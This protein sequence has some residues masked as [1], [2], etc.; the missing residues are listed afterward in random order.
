M[1][2]PR[3]GGSFYR[4]IDDAVSKAEENMKTILM[5]LALMFAQKQTSPAP[6]P[7][8]LKFAVRLDRTA[9]WVGDQFHYLIIVDSPAN[10]EFVLDNL[11][12]ETVNMDP[13]QVL[14]VHANPAFRDNGARRLF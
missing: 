13:F 2:V 11:T 3:R 10:Y 12:K 4:S 8:E 7:S 6:P 9:V 14:D 1:P 5:C